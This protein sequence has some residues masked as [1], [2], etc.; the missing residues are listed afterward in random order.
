[1][2]LLLLARLRVPKGKRE[3]AAK[4]NNPSLWSRAKSEAKKSLRYTHPHMLML[5]L[6]S[7]TNPRVAL[8]QAKITG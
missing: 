8:G 2:R 3:M 5:G 7:G 1:M 6:L 4:P